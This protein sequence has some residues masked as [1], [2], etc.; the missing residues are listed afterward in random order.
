MRNDF[1]EHLARLQRETAKEFLYVIATCATTAIVIAAAAM[2]ARAW[3][4]WAGG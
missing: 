4:A 3:L 2:T 1:D